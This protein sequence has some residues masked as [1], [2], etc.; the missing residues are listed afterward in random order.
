M[1][2]LT[3]ADV[4]EWKIAETVER[5]EEIAGKIEEKIAE[6]DAA[7]RPIA[8]LEL[9]LW[10]IKESSYG[11]GGRPPLLHSIKISTS[12]WSSKRE[13]FDLSLLREHS[14]SCNLIQPYADH[15]PRRSTRDR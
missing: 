14:Y 13:H 5:T 9:V 8:A 12:Q 7:N 6:K 11:R 15:F 4:I 1:A 10:P 2:N 3:M